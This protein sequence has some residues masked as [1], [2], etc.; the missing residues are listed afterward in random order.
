MRFKASAR[1]FVL[2]ETQTRGSLETQEVGRNRH[3]TPCGSSEILT[4]T[5]PGKG[6]LVVIS[7]HLK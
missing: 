3:V 2:Q 5:L 6:N 1:A 7:T 4:Q